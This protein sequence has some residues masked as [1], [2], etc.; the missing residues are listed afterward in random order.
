MEN[1]SLICLALICN[2]KAGGGPRWVQ[3]T[4]NEELVWKSHCFP[5]LSMIFF[6]KIPGLL[7]SAN[8][9]KQQKDLIFF[10]LL[11]CT[12]EILISLSAQAL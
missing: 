12:N 10:V 8:A 6:C 9:P 5:E 4:L 7:V 1:V 11:R 2:S 3:T